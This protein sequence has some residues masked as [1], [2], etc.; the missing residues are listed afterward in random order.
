M[1]GDRGGNEIGDEARK[2]T[3]TKQDR[4]RERGEAGK[5]ERDPGNQPSDRTGWAEDA[6]GEVTPTDNQQPP[7]QN[8][9][10]QRECCIMKRARCQGQGARGGIGEGGE[11]GVKKR[12]KAPG[13]ETESGGA[14]SGRSQKR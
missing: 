10:L 2:G 13:S 8:P 12:K 7:P 3:G 5:G 9:E 6:R 11:G 1:D 14:M 4:N